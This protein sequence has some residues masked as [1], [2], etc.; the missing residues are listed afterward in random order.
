MS[1]NSYSIE[2]LNKYYKIVADIEG[3]DAFH[4]T[5]LLLIMIPLLL[6]T[7]HK[8]I[9]NM[10]IARPIIKIWIDSKIENLHRFIV[11]LSKL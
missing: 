4:N 3:Y 10:G 2:H 9:T 8:C 6:N 11:L 1:S 7:E 5:I